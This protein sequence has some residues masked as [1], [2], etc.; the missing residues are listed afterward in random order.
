MN[1]VASLC[2]E[3][4]VMSWRISELVDAVVARLKPLAM[5]IGWMTRFPSIGR[6]LLQAAV[7]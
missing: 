7:A 3:G 2:L 4:Y 5:Q 6:A 1:V